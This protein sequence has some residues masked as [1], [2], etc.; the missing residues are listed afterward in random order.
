[1]DYPYAE[2]LGLVDDVHGQR[3]PDPYRYLE[4][5]ADERTIAWSAA[6]DGLYAQ[7]RTGWPDRDRFEQRLHELH[8]VGDVGSPVWRGER[9]FAMRRD[10]GQD[11]AVLRVIEPDGSSRALIDPI[12][13]DPSGSTTL[14]A[15]TPSPDG[16]LLAYAL[17]VGGT[18][19]AAVWVLDVDSG[20][21]VDGPV[22][23][24]RYP[25]IAWLPDGSGFYL[26]RTLSEGAAGDDDAKLHRR[27]HR[28]L[29]GADPEQEP[30]IFGDGAA[31]S[32]YF[33]VGISHDGRWLWVWSSRGT[34]PRND[35]HLADLQAGGEFVAVQEGVDAQTTIEVGRD[36]RAY[37]HTNRDA[38]RWRLC[39]ADPAELAGGY[40]PW[41]TLVAEDPTAVLTDAVR[42]D[43]DDLERPL[44]VVHRTRH[45]ISELAVHDLETGTPVHDMALPG[46][47]TVGSLTVR[48]DGGHEAWFGYEDFT[49]P[50]RVMAYDATAGLLDVWASPPGSI[51][52][53]TEIV[54]RQVT[55][56]SKD[57]TEVRMFVVARADV[58][59][60]PVMLNGYG[61]FNISLRP[62]YWP[63][64][65]AWIEA[66]GIFARPSLRGGGE[67]GHEWHRAG[68]R[69]SKQ[70]VFDDFHAAADW[71]VAQGLTSHDRIGIDGGS[72]GGLLVGA[73]LTQRPDAY[74][75]VIC[76]AP[77]LD[78]LR[79]ENFGLGS[80]WTGEY[81]TVEVAEEFEWL[82]A[83]SPYHHVQD[84]V[85]Y[86]AVL[87]SVYEGDS[88][89]DPLHARK[90]CAAM[91]H[92]TSGSAPIVMRRETAVGHGSRAVSRSIE[93]FADR[94]AFLRGALR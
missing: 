80:F 92:A 13:I 8:A 52:L 22:D 76:E 54:A 43:G 56:P 84:G 1:M 91:Q 61:G 73:A 60:G 71:L 49:T 37:L 27:V 38:P 23:R 2:R 82:R 87:F 51:T 6:Q 65:L 79:Y 64:R 68:M 89:V 48:R 12:V 36:G 77:L 42:L 14:D 86:P 33:D 75:A 11:H 9:G 7:V 63:Y 74:A 25:S 32:T 10:P 58:T 18:E 47:G 53:A 24:T 78:M 94:L 93:L 3:V 66:G 21:V 55:Y 28:H 85:A 17:S 30:A 83:Y 67:E 81:G 31:R 88:R 39:V 72:N 16:R 15:Y 70:N 69:E 59:D 5:P 20:A 4:D 44:L 34:D 40:G 35:L 46:L 19:Q 57:G 62:E 50:K 29:L 26:V 90:M 45:A 41:R